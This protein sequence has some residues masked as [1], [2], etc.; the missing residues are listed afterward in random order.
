[1]QP[2]RGPLGMGLDNPVMNNAFK[3]AREGGKH[4]G[5]LRQIENMGDRQVSKMINSM[6]ESIALHVR[7]VQNPDQIIPNWRELDS[8]YQS[9]LIA[10]WSKEIKVFE[11][12]LV[13]AK[14]VLNERKN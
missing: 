14:G 4:S 11:A 8:R 6:D 7:K 1:M 10:H 5:F 12:Q 2:A 13:I 3:E 9:G